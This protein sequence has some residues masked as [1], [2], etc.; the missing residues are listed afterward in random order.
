TGVGFQIAF[1]RGSI[2]VE[3]G[4]R[5][6]NI[7]NFVNLMIVGILVNRQGP[8][9]TD[10]GQVLEERVVETIGREYI[11]ESVVALNSNRNVNIVKIRIADDR[12]VGRRQL[13]LKAAHVDCRLCISDKDNVHFEG[14]RDRGRRSQ[15]RR[16]RARVYN[17]RGKSSAAD[18]QEQP[19]DADEG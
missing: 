16:L 9:A 18:E 14:C 5:Y 8:R 3:N 4:R 17:G 10:R 15:V 13:G 2:N 6:T 12:L 7:R 11:V 1:G 19:D